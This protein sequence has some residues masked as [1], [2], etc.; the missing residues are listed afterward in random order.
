MIKIIDFLGDEHRL[1]MNKFIASKYGDINI[2]NLETIDDG[3]RLWYEGI[4]WI[5]IADDENDGTDESNPLKSVCK[6]PPVDTEGHNVWVWTDDYYTH[7][8]SIL[9]MLCCNRGLENLACYAYYDY[10]DH[11]W[12]M[13]KRSVIDVLSAHSKSEVVELDNDYTNLRYRFLTEKERN[14]VY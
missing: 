7:S 12:Y 9:V 5:H 1:K 2:V 8:V 14:R 6:F 10:T 3:I 13:L 4:E 11:K